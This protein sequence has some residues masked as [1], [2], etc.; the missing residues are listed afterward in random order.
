MATKRAIAIILLMGSA[1]TAIGLFVP[2]H[3][4]SVGLFMSPAAPSLS[5]FLRAPGF[6]LPVYATND[7]PEYPPL[8]TIVFWS[9]L[10]A[11]FD[12]SIF[13]AALCWGTARLVVWVAAKKKT[14]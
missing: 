4:V 5:A 3:S 7:L 6:P 10:A 2:Y 1:L 12:V 9:N 11:N 14:A 13:I 8:G